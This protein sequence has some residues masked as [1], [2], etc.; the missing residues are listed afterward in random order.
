MPTSEYES[1]TYERPRETK[2]VI[3][4]GKIFETEGADQQMAALMANYISAANL[5]PNVIVKPHLVRENPTSHQEEYALVGNLGEILN[6]PTATFYEY[7]DGKPETLVGTQPHSGQYVVI[8]DGAVRTGGTILRTVAHLRRLDSGIIV[9][10]AVV[11]MV[12]P[13]GKKLDALLQRL[14]NEGIRLHALISSSDLIKRLFRSGYL[15]E[16]QLQEAM[17]DEDFH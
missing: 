7:D 16:A 9:R 10:D 4:F 11:Y 5:R 8:V 3:D 2:Y 14:S 6:K 1:P 17:S 15:S 13:E 12:R